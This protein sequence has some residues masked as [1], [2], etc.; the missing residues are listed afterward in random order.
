MPNLEK[1]DRD[2]L[3]QQNMR[4]QVKQELRQNFGDDLAN[5]EQMIQQMIESKQIRRPRVKKIVQTVEYKE[6]QQ[7]LEE[8]ELNTIMKIQQ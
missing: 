3:E 1:I 2:Q 5:D 7:D 8:E 4:L 6:S